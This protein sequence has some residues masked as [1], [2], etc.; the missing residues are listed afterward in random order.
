MTV[1][2]P[3]A[4]FFSGAPQSGS[5]QARAAARCFSCWASLSSRKLAGGCDFSLAAPAKYIARGRADRSCWRCLKNRSAFFGGRVVG[6]DNASQTRSTGSDKSRTPDQRESCFQN[7]A[8]P[9]PEGF[10]AGLDVGSPFFSKLGRR[11]SRF[12]EARLEIAERHREAAEL[13]MH[14]REVCEPFDVAAPSLEALVSLPRDSWR[15][16]AACRHGRGTIFVSGNAFASS[17]RSG[18]WG[19]SS[20]AS[21]V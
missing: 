5:R 18:S 20:Q 15:C 7:M 19:S 2:S 3:P 11:G 21:K 10:N 6:G 16:L 4:Q 14:V 13:H 1:P 12:R 17:I 8:R 9:G